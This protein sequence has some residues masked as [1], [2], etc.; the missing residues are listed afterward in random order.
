MTLSSKQ[1]PYGYIADLLSKG[2]VIP[3]LGTGVSLSSRVSDDKRSSTVPS[4]FEAALF[5]A[6]QINF[7]LD[8][9]GSV[10][11]TLMEVASYFADVAGRKALY[12]T[13]RTI[14][15]QAFHPS[16]MHRLLATLPTP[17]V[18]VTTSYDDLLERAFIEA[19]RP[20]D[21]LFTNID[22]TRGAVELAWW[23]SDASVPRI[24]LPKNF[25]VDLKRQPLIYKIYGTVNHKLPEWDSFVVTEDDHINLIS[26]IGAEKVIPSILFEIFSNNHFLFLGYSLRDWD[27]RLFLSKVVRYTASSKRSWAI[28][29]SPTMADA[30]LWNARGVDIYDSNINEIVEELLPRISTEASKQGELLKKKSS[31]KAVSM[32]RSYQAAETLPMVFISYAREDETEVALIYEHLKNDGFRPWLDREEILPGE[33]WEAKIRRILKEADFL[34][35]CL[36]SRSVGKKGFVQK[37]MSI[38]MNLALEMPPDS[39]FLIPIRLDAVDLPEQLAEYHYLDW[40]R[41]NTHQQ[42]TDAISEGWR[43]RQSLIHTRVKEL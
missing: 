25:F 10:Q 31:R 21:L 15:H 37:E 30:L 26:R 11:R 24:V 16:A 17:L 34:V 42:L 3:F 13:L 33:K 38:A 32:K 28:L 5:L 6:D 27:I 40:F 8:R 7:P 43:R 19:G 23:N 4:E 22:Q 39:I 41:E 36:S 20:Y 14:Y 9:F 35:L 18:I 1:V 29:R 12:A 2:R